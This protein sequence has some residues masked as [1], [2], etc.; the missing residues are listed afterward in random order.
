MEVTIASCRNSSLSFSETKRDCAKVKKNF[1]FSENST[2]EM[3][4]VTKA[5][6]VR[7]IG[8]PHLEVKRGMPFKHTMRRGP[9][10]KELQEK[11][12]AFPDSD[13]PR[14]LEDL[15]VKGVIQL[16]DP[17]RPEVVGRIA[18][19]KYCHYHRMVS[20]PLKKCIMIK[21]RIMQLAKEGRIIFELGQC[22]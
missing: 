1:K 16:P 11:K 6:L 21:E 19:P 4:T 13:L 5:E 10:L 14:M 2:K 15:L 17:K 8:K 7:I 22:S 3:M 9:T 20:H 18:D 12:Y